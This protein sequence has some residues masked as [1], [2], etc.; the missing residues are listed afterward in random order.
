[1]GIWGVIFSSEWGSATPKIKNYQKK[2]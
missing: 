1:M 2:P